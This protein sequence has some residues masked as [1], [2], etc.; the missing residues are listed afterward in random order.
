MYKKKFNSKNIAIII[1]SI[2]ESYLENNLKSILN[3]SGKIGKIILCVP[4]NC[5]ISLK[6]KKILILKSKVKN[7]VIQRCLA[8]KYISKNTKLIF[9]LD[10][11]FIL[12]K[13]S[14][15]QILNIW[16]NQSDKI[17]GI[18]FIPLNYFAPKSN[19]FQKILL[20]NSSC[21]GKVLSSGHVSAWKK[22]TKLKRV[23]WL[24]G[25]C[26]TWR[27]KYCSD[28]FNRKYPP[29]KW[30]VAE[31]LIYSFRK[32]KKYKLLI[33]NQVKLKTIKKNK[34]FSSREN[35]LRGYLHAKVIKNFVLYNKKL[36][37]L[38]Y[39]YS[40]ILSS[41]F[42]TILYLFFLDFKKSIFF[43]G[44]FIGCLSKTYNFKIT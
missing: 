37:L 5:S 19:L 7:Q 25:G 11:Q 33:S 24:H 42:G 8:K 18:G 2:G 40:M 43:L 28:I 17:A 36:S 44:R 1:S 39:Y 22:N 9:Q 20:T 34:Y 23:D 26:V 41:V 14:I 3:S 27:Y 30:S 35:Y 15:N 13:S 38:S 21:E 29:I 32:S 12:K 31:D 10:S 6:S 16:N 4:E